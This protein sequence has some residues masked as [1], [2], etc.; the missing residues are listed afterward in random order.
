MA[1][2]WS[3]DPTPAQKIKSAIAVLISLVILL[4]G[5]AA[6]GVKVY[7]WYQDYA[8]REDYVGDGDD[9]VEV[10]IP[11]GAGWQRAADILE[12]RGVIAAADTFMDKVEAEENRT[13]QEPVLQNG[14]YIMKTR[15]P[16]QTALDY[17]L[18]PANK[19]AI[20]VTIPEGERWSDQ[21]EPLLVQATQLTD[22][23]FDQAAADT[24]S[25]GLP[26]YANGQLEGYLFPDTYQLPDGAPAILQALVTNFNNKAAALDLV[27][28]AAAIGRSPHDVVVVASIIEEEV[29]GADD[30]AKVARAIYNRLDQGMPLGVESAFRYGRLQADGTPYD[31]PIDPATQQD[32]SLPYNYYTNPGLPQSAISNPGQAALEAALNPADGDWLYWV[33]VNLDTGETGFASDEAGFTALQQQF[34]QWCADNDNPTGCQ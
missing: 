25:L 20:S 19:V 27:N 9:S 7:G 29:S 14:E 2:R 34:Q 3:G 12:S 32:S 22:S 18:D 8:Q 1:M 10:I 6:A 11:E 21:I 24:A 26:D 15:W 13:G 16:A 4:G 33:T 5:G 17:L 23:D 28:K 30:M 31:T